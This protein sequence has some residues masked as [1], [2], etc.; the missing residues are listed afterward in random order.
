MLNLFWPKFFVISV[1]I[2]VAMVRGFFHFK[3][4]STTSPTLGDIIVGAWKSSPFLLVLGIGFV[5][6]L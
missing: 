4:I 3:T 1:I 2:V 5:L 6:I